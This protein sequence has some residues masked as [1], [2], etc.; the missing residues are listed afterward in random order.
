LRVDGNLAGRVGVFDTAGIR[1]PTQA[2][3]VF[4]RNRHTVASTRSDEWGRFQVVGLQAGI[5]SVIEVGTGGVAIFAERVLPF[6]ENAPK[7]QLLLDTNLVPTADSDL[8]SSLLV[9]EVPPANG[10]PAAGGNAPAGNTPAGNNA[11]SANDAGGGG[12]G[13]GDNGGLGALGV[14]AAAAMAGLGGGGAAGAGFGAGGG[15]APASPAQ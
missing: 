7:G 1:R 8:L 6:D 11:A 12:G 9:G 3:I 10:T 15:G 4:I 5:Y 14:A 13:G 2:R